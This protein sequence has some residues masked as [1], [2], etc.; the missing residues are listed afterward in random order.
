M[1][2]AF[3][4]L[5]SNTVMKNDAVGRRIHAMSSVNWANSSCVDSG[6]SMHMVRS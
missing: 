6:A 2:E 5:T 1:K 4:H 3:G